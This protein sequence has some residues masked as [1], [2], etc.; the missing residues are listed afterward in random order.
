MR[1]PPR[2]STTINA[3]AAEHGGVAVLHRDTHFTKLAEVLAFENVEL[4]GA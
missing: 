3:A 2:Q 4:P 1:S